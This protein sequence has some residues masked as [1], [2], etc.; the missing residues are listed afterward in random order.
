MWRHGALR[1][2]DMNKIIK[3]SLAMLYSLSSVK[4]KV[5]LIVRVLDALSIS[6]YS[7]E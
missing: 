5:S 3:A 7:R 4:V 1:G 6:I 2:S